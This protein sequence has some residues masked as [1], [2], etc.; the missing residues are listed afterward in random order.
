MNKIVCTVVGVLL[1]GMT[2]V[3][4]ETPQYREGVHYQRLPQPLTQLKQDKIEVAYFFWYGCPSCYH[5]AP[6][7]KTWRKTLPQDVVYQGSPA[8]W[9]PIMQLHATAFY[10]ARALRVLNRVHMAIFTA[11][12]AERN[13]LASFPAIIKLVTKLGVDSERFEKAFRS[14]GVKNMVRQS[15]LRARQYRVSG[16]PQIGINGKYLIA[17]NR[18]NEMSY[19]DMLKVANYLIEKER[20]AMRQS[21]V[22]KDK[23]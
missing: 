6:I 9:Q 17:I 19:S 20:Q 16:T 4:A 7:V 11:M 12:H 18:Q 13:N 3:W 22:K 21:P 10:A 14:F 2:C 8:I 5:F 1:F 15:E 23:P